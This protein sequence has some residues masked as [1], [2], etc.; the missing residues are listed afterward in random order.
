MT[1]TKFDESDSRYLVVLPS[2]DDHDHAEEFAVWFAKWRTR[3]EA[4][5]AESRFGVILVNHEHEHDEEERNEEEENAITALVTAFRREERGR[6]NQLTTGYASIYNGL[7]TD[8]QWEQAQERTARFAAYMFG[9]RGRMFKKVSAAKAWLNE[10]A[11]L[12]PLPLDGTGMSAAGETNTAIFY[13]STTGATELIAEK[14]QA[15]WQAEYGET[16]PIINVGD[17]AELMKLFSYERLLVGIPTWNVGKLQDDWE[18]VYPYLDQVDLSGKKIAMFGVGDQYGY[19][20]NFQDAL[21]IL[22]QKLIERGAQLLGYTSSDGY[23]H[24]HSRGVD[25]TG[26]FMGLAID[27]INQPELTDSRISDW[28]VQVCNEFAQ[29]TAVPA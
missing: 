26:R 25:E 2:D 11:E 17:S 21:G 23:E 8:E 12:D 20:E 13:G 22:G 18:I 24:S 9:V 27:D 5:T 19:P 10:I 14:V 3:L 15:L 29:E 4:A 7:M 1:S 16:L 6:V 28:I